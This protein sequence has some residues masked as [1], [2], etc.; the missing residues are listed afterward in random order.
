MYKKAK[1]KIVNSE[2]VP[3]IVHYETSGEQV[4]FFDGENEIGT[5]NDLVNGKALNNANILTIKHTGTH[6]VSSMINPPVEISGGKIAVL[7]SQAFGK[8]GSPSFVHFTFITSDGQ[9]FHNTVIGSKSSGW[10]SGGKSLRDEIENINSSISSS[11]N[12]IQTTENEITTIKEKHSQLLD[13]FEKHNHDNQYLKLSGG[14]VTGEV[15]FRQGANLRVSTPQGQKREL[16][17][18]SVQDGISFGDTSVQLNIKSSNSL[19]HNGKKIW[20]EVNHGKG[21]GLDADRLQGISGDQF[22]RKDSTNILK[23]ETWIE[24]GKSITFK[25]DGAS[26]G[27]YWY[28]NAGAHKSSIRSNSNGEIVFYQPNGAT[29]I[30]IDGAG[31]IQTNRNINLTATNGEV[32]VNFKLNA[33]DNGMY[34]Y[35]NSGSQYLGFWNGF[36]NK[37]MAFFSYNQGYLHFDEAPSILG[38]RLY[39]QSETPSGTK[40]VGDIWIS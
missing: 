15:T 23:G 6:L 3:E 39:M 16:V 29:N 7:S 31:N 11:Q 37:R 28:S 12:R 13:N 8:V 10:S 22:V 9:V 40:S 36:T 24:N 33:S 20:T 38:R 2:R 25:E 18:Y 19:L 21:S 26:S 1:Y 17:L 4:K 34:M 30:K 32:I 27:V 5:L 14:E 35:R